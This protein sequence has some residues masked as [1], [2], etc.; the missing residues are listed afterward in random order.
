MTVVK[1]YGH[2]GDRAKQKRKQYIVKNMKNQLQ[3]I[4]GT[5]KVNAGFTLIELLV[6]I[7]ILG[8]LAAALIATIDP[9]E[10]LKKAQD[11]NSKNTSAEFQSAV[12]RYYTTHSA[13]P[14]SKDSSCTTQAGTAFTGTALTS[15]GNCMAALVTDGELKSGFTSATDLLSGILVTGN[16][17]D[18]VACFKPVSKSQLRDPNT[19]YNT[20]GVL[21]SG[22]AS[23][24]GQTGACY[25]CAK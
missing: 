17:S 18:V 13:F 12:I 25:W 2:N 21:S 15:I 7:G 5:V 19:K 6:V 9:F 23:T 24:S 16:S 3:K 1:I 22:C 4:F 14:W 8:I 10:Q 11:A 20:A